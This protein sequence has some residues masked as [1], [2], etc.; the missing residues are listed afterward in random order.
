MI[1]IELFLLLSAVLFS[2]GLLGVLVRSNGIVILMC[3]EIMLNAANINFI[4]FASHSPEPLA[5]IFV[6]V[7]IAVAAAEVGVGIAI[8]L[9]AYKVRKSTNI[10]DL[11]TLRW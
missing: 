8:L 6:I 7:S 5:Q 11:T 1:P 4:A 3:I 2:I 9:R 10:D